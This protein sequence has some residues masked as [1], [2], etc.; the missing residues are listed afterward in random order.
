MITFSLTCV[1]IQYIIF[2]ILYGNQGGDMT[3]KSVLKE[4]LK[5]SLRL[6]KKYEQALAKLPKG[7]LIKKKIKGHEYYYLLLRERGKVKF[8]YKGKKVSPD[9]V[10][11][12][13]EAKQLRAKYRKL[14]LECKKQIKFLERSLKNGK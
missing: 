7:S 14:L 9:T 2:T 11:K 3:I 4:E 6:K 10:K 1:T 8:I 13:K 12:Y 5:N